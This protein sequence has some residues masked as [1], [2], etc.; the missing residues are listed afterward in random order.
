MSAPA[1]MHYCF[2]CGA[3][4]GLFSGKQRQRDLDTCGKPECNREARN[5][6]AEERERAHQELDDM[7]GWN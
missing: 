1:T 4:L 7:N 6:L 5:T 3:E 2:N